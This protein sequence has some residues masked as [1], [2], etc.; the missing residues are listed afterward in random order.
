MG[1][2]MLCVLLRSKGILV[3]V[4][5]SHERATLHPYDPS[6]RV[7]TSPCYLDPATGQAPC[8]PSPPSPHMPLQTFHRFRF[9]EHPTVLPSTK[10]EDDSA[11]NEED[12]GHGG[13][14]VDQGG[15]GIKNGG[16]C[17]R[18]TAAMIVTRVTEATSNR[19][20]ARGHDREPTPGRDCTSEVRQI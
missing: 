18:Q 12:D 11:S 10:D 15:Y 5:P 16:D 6:L 14:S 9:L 8:P 17:G 7:P 2:E 19:A 20:A 4:A 3:R 1:A 13:D